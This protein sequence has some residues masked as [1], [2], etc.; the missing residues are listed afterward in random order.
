MS[1]RSGYKLSI[2]IPTYAERANIEPLFSELARLKETMA[3]PFEVLIVDDASPDGTRE[4]AAFFGRLYGLAVRVHVRSEVRGLGTAIVTGLTLCDSD[5]V[6]VM[7][8]DLSHPPLLLPILLERLNG[9]DGVVASR[10]ANGGHIADWPFHRRLISF[11]A[12]KIVHRVLDV[13]CADPLSG[14]FLFHSDSLRGLPLTGLGNKPLLE[15][16]GQ[17]TVGIFE[18]PY[19][20][21]DRQAG[22]S[23]LT[24]QAIFEYV[25]LVRRLRRVQSKGRS[26]SER[27]SNES[28]TEPREAN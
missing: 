14:Y 21:H 20:F 13:K 12:T 23:K 24:A 9:F 28:S 4:A 18:V 17:R 16:L 22:K 25:L 3:I 2:I 1:G 10:Y 15:I 27:I 7:D 26:I 19:E 6:C 5:L 8:A 11:I